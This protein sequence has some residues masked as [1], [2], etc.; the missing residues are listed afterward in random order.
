[1][2]ELEFLKKD[3]QRKE[4]SLPRLTY[5]QIYEMIWKRSSSIV[6]WI[7]Y[8]SIIEFVFWATTSFLLKD[9]EFME[10][11]EAIDHMIIMQIFTYLGYAGLF[12]FMYLFFLNYK[13]ISTNDNVKKL[14]K[15]ILRTRKTVKNYVWFNLIYF[16]IVASITVV[17]Q[18]N[19]NTDIEM[20]HDKFVIDHDESFFYLIFY[21]ITIVS[22]FIFCVLIWLFYRL[23]YGILLGKLEKNYKELKRIDL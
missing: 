19:Q 3:W 4:K 7:F 17:I 14:L 10:S 11:Y 1:M 21:G 18:V 8:I 2:D 20:L 5:D 9:A 13:R 6:K 23:I 22:I 15:N 16:A 12:I